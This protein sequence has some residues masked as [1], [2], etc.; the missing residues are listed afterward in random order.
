M[1][2]FVDPVMCS[3]GHTYERSAIEKWLQANTTSPITSEG[4]DRSCMLPNITLRKAID[5]WRLIADRGSDDG[6]FNPKV[7]INIDQ[8]AIKFPCTQCSVGC[9]FPNRNTELS[10]LV[11]ILDS[12]HSTSDRR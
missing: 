1:D 3:D 2:V 5:E 6:I 7:R 4:L 10:M 8:R 9:T 12:T 11:G